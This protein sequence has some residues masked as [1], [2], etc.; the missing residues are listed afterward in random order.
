M[1]L[2]LKT[3]EIPLVKFRRL[4]PELL[5]PGGECFFEVEARA[6]GPVNIAFTAGTDR[7]TLAARVKDRGYRN[8]AD[9]TAYIAAQDVAVRE[10]IRERFGMLFDT[11]VIEWRCNIV[12]ADTGKPIICDRAT[13]IALLEVDA[14]PEITNA[15]IEVETAILKAGLAVMEEDAATLKN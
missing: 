5:G 14:W 6:G 8:E 12:D 1:P 13:F 3:R 9:D 4:F 2:K 15:M 11:C 7:L 10:I